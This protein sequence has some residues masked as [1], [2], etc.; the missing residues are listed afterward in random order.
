MLLVP[1]FPPQKVAIV[2]DYIMDASI[3]KVSKVAVALKLSWHHLDNNLTWN[4]FSLGQKSLG[5][6]SHLD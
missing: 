3:K 4:I 5:L 6:K 2:S 1:P